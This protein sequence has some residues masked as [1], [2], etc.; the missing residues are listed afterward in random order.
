MCWCVCMAFLF[1]RYFPRYHTTSNA[2]HVSE[3]D[4]FIFSE[5]FGD[6]WFFRTVK[7]S[8]RL[9]LFSN[10]GD[11]IYITVSAIEVLE[12][13]PP[14]NPNSSRGKRRSVYA[15]SLG[16]RRNRN[17]IIDTKRFLYPHWY[18]GNHSGERFRL[19]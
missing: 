5:C 13:K 8:R 11:T 7:E 19:Q 4:Y 2:L 10:L 3:R 12:C 9:R 6:A 15:H 18:P 14:W 1:L 17:D 16:A